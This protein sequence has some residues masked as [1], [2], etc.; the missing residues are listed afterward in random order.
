[1]SGV[2]LE[3]G[4]RSAPAVERIDAYGLQLPQPCQSLTASR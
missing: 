4:S 3:T 2:G 1:M